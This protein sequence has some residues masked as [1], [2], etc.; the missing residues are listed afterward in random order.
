MGMT[1]PPTISARPSSGRVFTTVRAELRAALSNGHAPDLATLR[2]APREEL[3]QALA[4]LTP[5]ELG[6]LVTRLGDEAVAELVAELDAFDAARLLRKLGRAQAA[7]VL[8]EMD[9][10]DA[11]DVVGGAPA[12]R[13]RG[14]PRRD[15]ARGGGG[16][17]RSAGL[18]AG[19]RGRHHDAGLRGRRAVPDGRRGAGAARTGGRRGR[20]DLLRLRHR[21]ADAAAARRALAAQPG[22]LAALEA[23]LAADDTPTSRASGPTPIRRRRPAC[24]TSNS[25]LALPVVDDQDR[26]LGI[27]TA[28]DAADVLLEEAGEDIER[29]G[30]S[31]PLEEPYLRA[32]I[33]APVP[34]A[35]RLAAGA[36]RGR[37]VHRHGA[38]PLRGH[39]RA[40]WS[41][42]RSSSRC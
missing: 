23:G 30:G 28:D 19:E 11:A 18:P 33:V 38:A 8:E 16:R 3:A 42:W 39:A 7:D 4:E 15:G 22:A 29:L 13:G 1:T 36:V 14:D 20:D 26:L 32:S 34:Q 9:P 17:P 21:S 31:Q 6:R 24:W 40:R 37:G 27:I 2:A 35:G 10:D 5:Q 41:R 12:G 25:Y